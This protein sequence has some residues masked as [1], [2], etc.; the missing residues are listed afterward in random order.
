MWL[1]QDVANS[2]TQPST[3]QGGKKR[4]VE[5]PLEEEEKPEEKPKDA[6]AHDSSC[7]GLRLFTCRFT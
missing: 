1:W 3:W 6:R 7:Q 5:E 4:R 2:N